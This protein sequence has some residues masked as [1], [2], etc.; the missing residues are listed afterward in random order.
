MKTTGIYLHIPFCVAKCSYCTFNSY[1]GLGHLHDAYVRALQTEIESSAGRAMGERVASIYV[2][3]GTPTVLTTELL[4]RVLRTCGEHYRV[5]PEAEVSMEA[6]PGTVDA[7]YLRRLRALGVTRLSLGVQSFQDR[8]LSILARVHTSRQAREAFLMARSAGF[9]SVN[10]D[11]IYGLPGQSLSQWLDDL[12]QALDLGPEHLSLYG[13]SLEEGTPLANL[14]GLGE[15]P[16]PDPDLAATMYEEAEEMLETAGYVHYEISNWALAGHECQHNLN[17]WLNR[18]Y[19]GFGAG[20]HSFDGKHRRWNVVRPEEYVRRLERGEDPA[21]GQET[22]DPAMERSETM[23]LGL[24]LC[25]GVSSEGF[26]R[27]F[28][29]SLLEAFADQIGDLVRLG[30]LEGDDGGVRLTPRGRLLG[31]EVFERFLAEAVA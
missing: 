7:S 14:V 12:Y 10:L 17:Y 6:N 25:R 23:I 21:A 15:L 24:R 1:A 4:Q 8:M 29:L 28:G 11:L 22:I 2:G 13:L 30:L 20:A 18:P 31:N 27:R 19:L 5:L 3:G 26:E 16:P 9:T